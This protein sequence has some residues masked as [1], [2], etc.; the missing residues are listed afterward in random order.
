VAEA[1]VTLA[2]PSPDLGGAALHG[3]KWVGAARVVSETAAFLAVVVVAHLVPPAEYGRAAVAML[4]SQIAQSLSVQGI[5]TPVVRHRDLRPAHLRAAAALSWI[6]G[7]TTTIAAVLFA[8]FVAPS[9]FG[10]RIAGLMVLMAPV[11]LL[12]GLTAI[13]IAQLQ[14]ALDFR[15]LATVESV[16]SVAGAA[17]GVA[18]ALAGLDGEALVIGMLVNAACTVGILFFVAPRARPGFHPSEMWEIARFGTPATASGLLYFGTRN[19]DFAILAGRLSATQLGY[20]VRAFQLGS[21]Y[22]GKISGV[23]L[24]VAFPVFSRAQDHSQLQRARARMVSVHTALIF[25]LLF[26]LIAVAPVLVPWMFGE[27]WAPAAGPTQIL[28]IVGMV[29]AVG[30]GTGPLLLAVGRPGALLAYNFGAFVAYAAAVLVAA[31]YGITV[32]C[33]VVAVVKVVSL[34]ALLWMID[35]LVDIPIGETL[36]NDVVP[37]T[38]GGLGLLCAAL[39]VCALLQDTSVPAPVVVA[40]ATG[41]GGVVYAMILRLLFRR[42]WRDLAL[43]VDRV[44]PRSLKRLVAGRTRFFAR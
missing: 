16:A 12:V 20:Y 40:L 21:D 23:M 29:A 17:A 18:C 31:P 6:V 41:V 44:A 34:L 8:E 24:R 30:T 11:F 39:P 36:V 25:P 42:T 15:R 43:L 10:D 32:V 26:A 37:A 4:L 22:Q 27:R 9:L 19:V 1:H 5:G 2:E 13:P 38:I 14:R 7:V 28:A 33:V 35:A 3:V